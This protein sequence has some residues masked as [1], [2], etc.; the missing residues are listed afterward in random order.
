MAITLTYHQTM[1][2]SHLY[3]EKSVVS[4]PLYLNLALIMKVDRLKEK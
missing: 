4:S 2:T 1:E 3:C